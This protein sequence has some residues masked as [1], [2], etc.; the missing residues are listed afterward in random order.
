[1][2]TN[3]TGSAFDAVSPDVYRLQAPLT[4]A[5]VGSLRDEGVRLIAAAQRGLTFDLQG[6]PD[7]DSAG[8]ALLID[9]LAAAKARSCALRYAQPSKTLLALARLSDVEKLIA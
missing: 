1:M 7:V 9:W 8:L 6:V 2:A 3:G 5:S 4:F